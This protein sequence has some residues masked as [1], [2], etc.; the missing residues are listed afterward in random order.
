MLANCKITLYNCAISFS[1]VGWFAVPY[2]GLTTTTSS[3]SKRRHREMIPRKMHME[4]ILTFPKPINLPTK[5]PF[6]HLI[7][8]IVLRIG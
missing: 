4:K 7:I 3:Y 5:Q 6:C 2:S 8:L 1:L